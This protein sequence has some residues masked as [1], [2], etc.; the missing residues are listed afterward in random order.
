MFF[1]AWVTLENEAGEEMTYRIVG[2]DELDPKKQYISLDSPLARALLKKT[3]DDEV[4]IKN[5]LK[6]TRYTVV[7][8]HYGN[9]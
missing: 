5:E 2:A 3:F 8:I 4:A 6:E 9:R 1:S 7:D